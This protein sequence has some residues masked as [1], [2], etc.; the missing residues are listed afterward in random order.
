MHILALEPYYGGSHKAFLDGWQAHSTHTWHTLSLPD[1]MWRWRMRHA[2][3]T[4]AR[5]A[6]ALQELL[7]GK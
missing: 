6:K 1:S 2:A 4:F 3:V 5:E 7:Y